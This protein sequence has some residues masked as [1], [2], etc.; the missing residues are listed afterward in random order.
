MVIQ[1]RGAQLSQADVAFQIASL[2][3]A[4]ENC[5]TPA[6]RVKKNRFGYERFEETKFSRRLSSATQMFDLFDCQIAYDYSEHLQVFCDACH[7]IR[8]ERSPDGPVCL[9]ESGTAYLSHAQSMN[10]LV[11]RIRQLTQQQC[12]RRRK[13]VR[14]ELAKRQARE[15]TEYTDV[16]MDRYSRTTVVRVN[17]YYRTECHARL[18][19]EHVFDDLDAMIAKHSRRSVFDHLIGYAYAVEQGDRTGGRGYH[20]HAAYF[21]N[22]N[23]ISCDIYKA[24]EICRMWE[25][26]TRSQGIAHSSNQEGT[27]PGDKRGVGCIQKNDKSTREKTYEL[28]RYLVKLA[29]PLHLR[30]QSARCLRRGTLRSF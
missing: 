19:V 22:G 23:K 2:V 11:A 4:I 18:R 15:I 30:P 7:D 5:E 25:E 13:A 12:Y 3:G 6:F 14:R 9:N 24:S 10:V 8:L 16:V 27:P 29:Q 1:K 28:M 26:V 20:I 17:F 21:F